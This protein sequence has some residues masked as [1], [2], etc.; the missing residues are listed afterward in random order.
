MHR[1]PV[2]RV[3]GTAL[4]TGAS[5]GI[6]LA[7]ARRLAQGGWDLVLVA[8]SETDL[9]RLASKLSQD[10]GVGAIAIV[11]DLA[12]PPG[13]RQVWD[14]VK[15]RDISIDLLI[16]NAGVGC[17]GEVWTCEEEALRT[18]IALNITAMTDLV[19][20][21]VPQMI[22][23]RQGMI[24]NIASTAALWPGPMM[25]SYAASKA[26]VLHLTESLD[27]ELK[28]TGVR[29][30]ALC[31]GP[32]RTS[33]LETPGM[34]STGEGSSRRVATADEFAAFAVSRLSSRHTI[35][36]HGVVNRIAARCM[37]LIPR[38]WQGRLVRWSRRSVA[39]SGTVPR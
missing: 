39:R 33:F 16:N 18:M 3:L 7:L 10:Y 28:D 2:H 8:R 31:P 23:R 20:R 35:A 4:V 5:R 38:S 19:R 1:K 36:V 37:T 11:A 24:V 15:R 9:S 12:S 25:A 27:C 13:A 21:F 14:Q 17:Y 30:M 29:A 34:R 6:G 22:E 32:T 26:Y